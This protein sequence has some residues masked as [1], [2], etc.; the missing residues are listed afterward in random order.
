MMVAAYWYYQPD[1][2]KDNS[3]QKNQRHNQPTSET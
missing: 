3:S 1:D 2:L